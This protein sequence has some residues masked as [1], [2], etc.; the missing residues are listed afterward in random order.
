MK[1][2][3]EE[4]WFSQHLIFTTTNKDAGKTSRHLCRMNWGTKRLW[5]V[6]A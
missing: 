4:S 2:L 6:L 3:I 5:T 1:P